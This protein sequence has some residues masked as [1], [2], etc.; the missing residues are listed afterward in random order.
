MRRHFGRLP[1]L[2]AV[3]IGAS[4]WLAVSFVSGR[5][6][7]WDSAGYWA[8]GY[9]LSI[10][11][12]AYLGYSYPVRSWRWALLLFQ[13]QFLAGCLR[14]GEVG[15]LWPLGIA[16]F[17]IMSLPGV[18]AAMLGAWWRRRSRGAGDEPANRAS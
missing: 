2:L 15:N 6:E 14:A 9:P 5:R 1:F 17:A 12:C 4:L 13:A 7:A 11:A 18:L 3:V 8:L 10:V 16:L